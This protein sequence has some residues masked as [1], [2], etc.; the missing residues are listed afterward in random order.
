[1]FGFDFLSLFFGLVRVIISEIA[2]LLI[3]ALSSYI[4]FNENAFEDLYG[5]KT[6][7]LWK[8]M[9][10]CGM[11]LRSQKQADDKSTTVTEK[12]TSEPE[13]SHHEEHAT[14]N[15]QHSTINNQGV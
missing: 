9:T 4:T 3:L 6:L 8:I 10:S 13:T 2:L 15:P 14:N 7:R 11:V 12:N 1:M 5:K